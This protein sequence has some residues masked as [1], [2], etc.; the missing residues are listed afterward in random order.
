MRTSLG[1]P[2]ICL[3]AACSTAGGT[4]P[5]ADVFART[6]AQPQVR[7][8]IWS[9]VPSP[10]YPP[11]S[12]G[13]YADML[14][15]VSGT[16]SNDV[17][18]VGD[19]CCVAYGSKF[20]DEPLL[21][22]WNG[23]GWTIMQ[24][25]PDAPPGTEFRAVAAVSTD[26]V[27]AVGY[28]AQAV[29]EHW[30]GKLWKIVPS[31]YVYNNGEMNSVVAISKNNVWAAGEGNFAAILEQWNG[32]VWSYIPG[33]TYGGL[34]IINSISA[35][36]PNDIWAVGE[37]WN[38][39]P[40]AFSE[41]WNGSTWTNEPP[42]ADFAVSQLNGVADISSTDAWAVG[43]ETAT[44]Q[45]KAR[46][47]LI[48][49]WNGSQWSVVRSPNKDPKGSYPL[50]NLL[51]A[52]TARSAN[53][54]WAVGYWTWFTGDGTPRS[55][56]LHWN[57]KNWRIQSGPPPLESSNN[58]ASNVLQGMTSL[59]TGELWAVGNQQVPHKCCNHTLT[60]RTNNP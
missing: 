7:S 59:P 58:A 4:M 17:W 43:Y 53:D 11:G 21:E 42:H 9:V 14:Y 46:Q 48:E 13:D 31:P 24:S 27:W 60:A 23:S 15:G 20:L 1:L 19:N 41:H 44:Y 49:H 29:F 35:S 38:P 28:S 40:V 45:S 18:A 56:F 26:D 2:A 3:V 8:S 51:Y 6:S 30:N 25:A 47:T 22:H 12:D 10:D 39:N 33:Y 54:V 52:V 34:T 37:Y 32:K 55:L 36:G 57:G 5:S 16:S 50:T